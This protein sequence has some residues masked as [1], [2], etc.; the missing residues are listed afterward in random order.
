MASLSP[1]DDR[2]QSSFLIPANHL[3]TTPNANITQSAL[4]QIPRVSCLTL[5][6]YLGNLIAS[7]LGPWDGTGDCSTGG[8]P[9]LDLFLETRVVTGKTN[10]TRPQI[11]DGLA[12]QEARRGKSQT[13]TLNMRKKSCLGVLKFNTARLAAFQTRLKCAAL[14]R[15]AT[16]S[17]VWCLVP[18]PQVLFQRPLFIEQVAKEVWQGYSGCPRLEAS[19]LQ[20]NIW[21]MAVGTLINSIASSQLNL[22]LTIGTMRRSDLRSV[23]HISMLID[24]LQ[25]LQKLADGQTPNDILHFTK[26]AEGGPYRVFGVLFKS[27]RNVIVRLPYP[28]TVPSIY[29]VGHPPRSGGSTTDETNSK[30]IEVHVCMISPY[31]DAAFSLI[32]NNAGISTLDMLKAI[33]Q[34]ELE[35]LQ[36][37]DIPR[38]PSEPLYRELYDKKMVGPQGQI[39]NL[40]NYLKI[41]PY[42][43]LAREDWN[44]PTI[45]HPD[46]SPSNILIDE[47]GDNITRVID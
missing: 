23:I 36:K 38:Y 31:D 39:V 9:P 40:Q 24:S 8:E 12:G 17:P 2:R 37:F 19:F 6:G 32:T 15:F 21:N 47:A 42:I 46:L 41:A 7:E 26:L 5:P 11:P 45:R 1:I 16:R 4:R 43:V 27:Q 18:L 20:S 28:C 25:S 13:L 34:R 44:R 29:G 14:I 10:T 22:S 35:W 30:L 33:G 3:A